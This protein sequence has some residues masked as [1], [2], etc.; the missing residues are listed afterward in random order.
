MLINPY[1]LVDY[2]LKENK[3]LNTYSLGVHPE[4]HSLT[5]CAKIEVGA[6]RMHTLVSDTAYCLAT[7]ITPGVVL[8]E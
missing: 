2:D 7:F 5:F 3:V 1:I 6:V 4:R 8:C